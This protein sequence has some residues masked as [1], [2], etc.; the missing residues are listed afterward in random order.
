[1]TKKLLATKPDGV[2]NGGTMT[3]GDLGVSVG[4]SGTGSGKTADMLASEA[5]NLSDMPTLTSGGEPKSVLL[6]LAWSPIE[7]LLANGEAR[8]F[9]GRDSVAVIFKHTNHLP[10]VGLVPEG[11]LGEL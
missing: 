2:E 4:E 1:M 9:V 11:D 7:T 10:T 5:G 6:A 8:M 3:K